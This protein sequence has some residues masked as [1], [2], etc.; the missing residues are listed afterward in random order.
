M[1]GSLENLKR[2]LAEL[3]ELGRRDGREKNKKPRIAAGRRRARSYGS[4]RH[5]TLSLL[6]ETN[7]KKKEMDKDPL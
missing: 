6:K 5:M 7:M 3:S 2:F 4:W 1:S